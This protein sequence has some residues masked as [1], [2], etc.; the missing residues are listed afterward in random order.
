MLSRDEQR[1]WDDIERFYAAEAEEP[2][3]P[4]PHPALRHRRDG[5]GAGDL[6]VAVVA[7]AWSAILLI[8]FGVLVAGFAVGAATALGWWLWRHWSLL[9]GGRDVAAAG[10]TGEAA[11]RVRADEPWHRR[12]RR[13]SDTD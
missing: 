9:R 7:G 11:V 13:A 6:P 12:L 3:L 10:P 1:I 2:V 5:R 8:L 4:V